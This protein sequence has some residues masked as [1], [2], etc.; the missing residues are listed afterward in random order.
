LIGALQRL[1]DQTDPEHRLFGFIQ[2]F[3]LPSAFS[4]SFR[5]TSAIIAPQAPV[6]SFQAAL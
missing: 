5:E 3:H 4:G 6:I 2:Q 1:R